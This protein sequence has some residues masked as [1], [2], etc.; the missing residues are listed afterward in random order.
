[1]REAAQAIV[2]LG[3]R[4]VVVKG[5]HLAG[6]A[7]DVFYDGD[8]FVELPARRIETTSTHGT[9]CTL[10]S[11]IAALLARGESL[12]GAISGA[13]AYVTAAIERAYPIGHGHGPVHH[14]HRWW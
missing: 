3:A 9:G 13:K 4:S 6:D 2:G 1:M 11:A 12:E 7:I 5:G 10:A 14:F 8:R